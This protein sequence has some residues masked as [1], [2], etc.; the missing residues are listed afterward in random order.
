MHK[1]NKM[2]LNKKY[3]RS[4]VLYMCLYINLIP[5]FNAPWNIHTHTLLFN[6]Y[7]I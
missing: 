1:C 7:K 6:L 5:P 3:Q 2:L 4:L